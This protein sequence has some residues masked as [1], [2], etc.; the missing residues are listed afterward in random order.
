MADK[1]IHQQEN[2]EFDKLPL[3]RDQRRMR[4]FIASVLCLVGLLCLWIHTEW[5][6]K[7][8]L[9]EKLAR[10]NALTI[11]AETFR[12]NWFSRLVGEDIQVTP[13]GEETLFKCQHLEVRFSPLAWL[14]GDQSIR[15][16][17]ASGADV[18]VVERE[19]GSSNL[20]LFFA[21]LS[22]R[23]RNQGKPL[24][25]RRLDEV[26]VENSQL[27]FAWEHRPEAEIVFEGI[28]FS[29]NDLA[30]NVD[31]VA[32]LSTAIQVKTEDGATLTA[33][34]AGEVSVN[35]QPSC[36]PNVAE[37]AFEFNF[38]E[39][40]DHLAGLNDAV[41][42][43]SVA[44]LAQEVKESGFRLQR[45]ADKLGALMVAGPFISAK[46]EGQLQVRLAELDRDFVSLLGALLGFD[47]SAGLLE[48][49]STLDWSFGG[50]VVSA[51]GQFKGQR[52]ALREGG[53]STPE[54]DVNCEYA[55]QY[56]QNDML[57]LLQKCRFD[58]TSGGD[59]W[60][61]G[62]LDSPVVIR[63]GNVYQGIRE[64]NF[65]LQLSNVNLRDWSHVVSDKVLNGRLFFDV[66]A[67]IRRD[68]Q[69]IE[70]EATGRLEGFTVPGSGDERSETDL[71]F[72][73]VLRLEELKR[74]NVG[75]L[76][77][78]WTQGDVELLRGNGALSYQFFDQIHNIQL[79]TRGQI[80]WFVEHAALPG[81]NV[82]AG[83]FDVSGYIRSKNQDSNLV[84][85][86]SLVDLVGD[87]RGL[88]INDYRFDLNADAVIGR[89]RVL[90]NNLS[91]DAKRS[92]SSGGV[93]G[94]NGQFDFESLIGE[95]RFQTV[96]VN[97]HLVMPLV[98]SLLR[99][100]VLDQAEFEIKGQAD[101]NLNGESQL[102]GSIGVQGLK[103]VDEREGESLLDIALTVD[104]RFD[105]TAFWV[106]EAKLILSPTD[107]AVN[108]VQISGQIPL[109]AAADSSGLLS[110][111][112]RSLDLTDYWAVLD[113]PARGET[114]RSD[115]R[116][117]LT[118]GLLGSLEGEL[119]L[120]P[121][122]LTLDIGELFLNDIAASN[123]VVQGTVGKDLLLLDQF[124]V[125][126]NGSVSGR[127]AVKNN[128]SAMDLSVA[129]SAKQ[130]PIGPLY[131]SFKSSD[132]ELI[133]G[134]VDV[135]LT[136]DGQ[137]PLAGSGGGVSLTGNVAVNWMDPVVEPL[138]MEEAP[139]LAS[140]VRAINLQSS[141]PLRV[142][143]ISG[144]ARIVDD[145]ATVESLELE[146]NLLQLTSTGQ[147]K[148]LPNIGDSPVHLPVAVLMDPVLAEKVHLPFNGEPNADGLSLVP[149]FLSISGELAG[150]E[151]K[152]DR[153]A[154]AR[155]LAKNGDN[156]SSSEESAASGQK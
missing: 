44:I 142:N 43:L 97:K 108:E 61:D 25:G 24:A 122:G 113:H 120:G 48:G 91:V 151:L 14:F 42:I 147:F 90:V 65:K 117:G 155:V 137:V 68:G 32:V 54:S 50:A 139:W 58:A 5:F 4:Q 93:I 56:N 41:G 141:S 55:F 115:G 102:N 71:D 129:A 133:D 28:N 37:G 154:L 20:A 19:N 128:D 52:V 116:D 33:E 118:R 49:R 39:G 87:Y 47:L 149:G 126:L 83:D 85:A 66:T 51:R 27:R 31:T 73:A 23:P 121:L 124:D 114:T 40:T 94:I 86:V 95:M 103:Y 127:V 88:E 36:W 84:L 109:Q 135:E 76:E 107:L 98:G 89:G 69:I 125:H 21:N 30:P 79:S 45:G 145:L 106:E 100:E 72:R 148:V 29:L 74:L 130:V 16:L 150:L 105:Q 77:F 60:L 9:L 3:S 140:I 131:R 82:S 110:L 67:S 17:H 112:A 1:L 123:F 7:G 156:G 13:L 119:G 57:V 96:G 8:Y 2:L 62:Y 138:N 26:R 136:L 153:S 12:L 70:A 104:S 99:E 80:P 18:A 134:S 22:T 38:R 143:R 59:R 111:R 81:L 144:S 34:T 75:N 146:A 152:V 78:D 92:H 6:A 64:S 46:K 63:W 11:S 101:L 10:E 15:G 132:S 35:L 53:V